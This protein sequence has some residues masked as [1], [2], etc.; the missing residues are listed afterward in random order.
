M[1][2]VAC[3]QGGLVIGKSSKECLP[4]H[5][6]QKDYEQTDESIVLDRNDLRICS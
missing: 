5:I 3:P 1:Y 4:K 2:Q 6:K